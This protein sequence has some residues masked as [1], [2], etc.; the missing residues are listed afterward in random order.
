MELNESWAHSRVSGRRNMPARERETISG[1]T[2][3]SPSCPMRWR[4]VE[5]ALSRRSLSTGLVCGS[6]AY[7][8]LRRGSAVLGVLAAAAAIVAAVTVTM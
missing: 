2:K 1:N 4:E 5:F 8:H 7:S 3:C 6:R